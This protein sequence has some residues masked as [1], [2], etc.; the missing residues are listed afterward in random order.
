[1]CLPVMM[2]LSLKLALFVLNL[3]LG[4]TPRQSQGDN[5][6]SDEQWLGTECSKDLQI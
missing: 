2:R 5:H 1:M 6:C 3:Q 4:S